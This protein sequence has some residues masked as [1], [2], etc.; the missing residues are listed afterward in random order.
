ML[1]SVARDQADGES[2]LAAAMVEAAL[3][4]AQGGD[5]AARLFV[6]TPK[7]LELWAACLDVAPGRLASLAR[8]ALAPARR[9]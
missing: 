2:R 1:P 8:G 4:D 9:P 5:R 7:R 6:T 3:H